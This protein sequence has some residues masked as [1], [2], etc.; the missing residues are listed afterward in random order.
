MAT[1]D[2]RLEIGRGGR[3]RGVANLGPGGVAV[4]NHRRKQLSNTQVK[5]LFAS[6]R[7]GGGV[8]LAR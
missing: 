8:T 3:G 4:P 6:S 1:V 2:P 7:G 5:S